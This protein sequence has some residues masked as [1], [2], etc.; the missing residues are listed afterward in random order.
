M[1]KRKIHLFIE[2]EKGSFIL[3]QKLLKALMVLMKFRYAPAHE[4][5]RNRGREAAGPGKHDQGKDPGGAGISKFQNPKI[6]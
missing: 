6:N 2:E 4:L 5:E 3:L 1:K